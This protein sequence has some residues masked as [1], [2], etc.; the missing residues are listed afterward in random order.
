MIASTGKKTRQRQPT[1][2][3]I[4]NEPDFFHLP[5]SRRK[6]Q[7]ARAIITVE[8]HQEDQHEKQDMPE[9][10]EEERED[11]QGSCEI[12]ATFK[13]SQLGV[14]VGGKVIEGTLEKDQYARI[15]RNEEMIWEGKILSLKRVKDDVKKVE[16]GFECG[17]VLSNFK[18][19]EPGD[20]IR[21]H[22]IVYEEQEL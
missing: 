1:P 21:T 14:I 12:L 8:N 16:K 4:S 22:K 20:I 13:S 10:R 2:L 7:L 6:L 5:G 9:E 15:F 19:A 18:S 3:A 17:M 11:H